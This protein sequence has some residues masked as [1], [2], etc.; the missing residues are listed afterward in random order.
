MSDKYLTEHSG[1]LDKLLPRD[2]VLADRGFDIR[3]SVGSLCA[4]VKIPAFTRGKNQISPLNLESARKLAQSRI[5]V[6]RVI[7]SLRQK[8]TILNGTLPIT[9][10]SVKDC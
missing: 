8:Y 3:D 9:F 4:E 1:F 2:L 6:E 5:H 10:V 7:G